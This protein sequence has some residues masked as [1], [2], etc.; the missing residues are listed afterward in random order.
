MTADA[1]RDRRLGLWR[2][3]SQQDCLALEPS[4]LRDL[5]IYGGAAGIW[6]DK[7]RTAIG[8]DPPDGIT[9]S[10]LHTGQHY[11]DD[12]SDDC[13]LYHYPSTKRAPSH[14]A[15]EVQATKNA[16]LLR[17]PLFVVLPSPRSQQLREVK[18]GWV[19]DFDD[20]GRTFLILYESNDP[21]ESPASYIAPD[22]G[23][24]PFVGTDHTRG[25]S[26]SSRTSRPNQKRFSFQVFKQFGRQCAVCAI[27]HP[28]LL[29]AA[30]IRGIED[31]GSD[32]WRNGIP[33]CGTHH[34]AFDA[35]LFG[36]EP[37]TL[38]L[39]TRAGVSTSEIGL[40]N[41]CLQPVRNRPHLEA[42]RWRWDK[43]RAEWASMQA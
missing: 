13:L 16:M 6:R 43:T 35:F 27:R 15:G 29:K 41:A 33:L 36:I 8:D 19:A 23:D 22:L 12:L 21:A 18:L 24:I 25:R 7:T 34:D 31:N 38:A 11:D 20:E 4:R 2:E 9:V 14:D 37:E 3:L 5:D 39:H 30:H 1:E 26:S 17:M 42:L 28:A 40:T 32:D 10:I